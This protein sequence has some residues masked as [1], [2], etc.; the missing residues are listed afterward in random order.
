MKVPRPWPD[1]QDEEKRKAYV[2]LIKK[3]LSD[4][5]IDLWFLDES[6]IEGDPRPRRRFATKGEKILQ[7]YSGA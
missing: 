2:G 1:G 4:Q 3:W 7:P 5:N 6:G